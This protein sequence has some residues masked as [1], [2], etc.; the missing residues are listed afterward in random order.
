MEVLADGTSSKGPKPDQAEYSQGS[1]EVCDVVWLLFPHK[2]TRS[3]RRRRKQSSSE[4]FS[5][6]S[7]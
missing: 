6:N 5:A 7:T 4:L 1:G 3:R 2:T